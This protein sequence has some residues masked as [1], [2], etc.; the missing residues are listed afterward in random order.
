MA[1]KTG[2]YRVSCNNQYIGRP[3]HETNDL[4]PKPIFTTTDDN[5]FVWLVEKLL[6]SPG[7][8]RLCTGI[9]PQAPTGVDPKDGKTVVGFVSEITQA[10]E[11]ELRPV[12][13]ASDTFNIVGPDGNS[14]WVAPRKENA[15]IQLLEVPEGSVFRFIPAPPPKKP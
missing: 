12:H 7:R 13:G 4:A 6:N 15:K 8:Y 2:H 1:L 9:F 3:I 14:F 10:L 5:D 11:W